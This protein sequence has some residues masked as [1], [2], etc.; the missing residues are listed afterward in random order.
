MI[1]RNGTS[2]MT[3]RSEAGFSLI[4]I[5]IVVV[6]VGILATIA[7]PAYQDSVRKGQ[8]SDAK[9]GL[10]GVASRMEQFMLDRGTYTVDMEDLAT[11]RAPP[12][13]CHTPGR[14]ALPVVTRMSGGIRNR[15]RAL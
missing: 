14:R 12:S 5:I 6:I 15:D 3:M 2:L 9:A 11:R 7:L 4:E 8:R 1:A 10:L 13:C